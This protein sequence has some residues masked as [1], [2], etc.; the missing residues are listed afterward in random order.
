VCW[1]YTVLLRMGIIPVAATALAGCLPDKTK[2]LAACRLE[3]DRFYSG[4]DVVA[5]TSPVSQYI[6]GCMADK[7]FVFEVSP[8]DCVGRHPLAIQPN[9][10]APSSWQSWITSRF[11]F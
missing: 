10:Y 4:P 9:C 8:A 2:D 3:A 6:I 1:Q 11:R 7:G 5:A